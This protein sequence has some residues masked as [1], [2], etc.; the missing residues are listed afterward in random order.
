LYLICN[1]D[2][3]PIGTVELI[4][5]ENVNNNADMVFPFYSLDI[6]KENPAKIFEIDK[7]SL[8]QKHRG[9]NIKKI[10]KTI[11]TYALKNE[12]THGI[13]LLEPLFYRA[14]RTFYKLP[15]TKATN[16]KNFL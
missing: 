15:I 6:V 9:S 16:E 12:Y 13:M 10:L 1:D 3:V 4:P 11:Y 14:L 2:G 7:V 8:S 5:Y